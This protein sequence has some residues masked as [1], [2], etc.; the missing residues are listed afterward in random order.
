MRL[1]IA[2]HFG[3]AVAATASPHYNV[4]DRRRIE[5]VEPGVP[6][7]PI[8]HDGKALDDAAA[9]ALVALVRASAFRATAALLDRLAASLPE[10]IVTM[11]LRAWPLDFPDDIAVQRRV[12][13][14]LR[15]PRRFGMYRLVLAELANER[16]WA[17]HLYA[18][19]D[20]LG[21]AADLLK[22]RA[23]GVL[24]GPRRT[25]GPPWTK[26]HR[27]ALATAILA[28]R[29]AKLVS[30]RRRGGAGRRRRSRSR[31]RTRAGSSSA[32]A[33]VGGQGCAR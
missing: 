26:D 28:V 22:D 7:A 10:P 8:H 5:L 19:G 25:L 24:R 21:Q 14:D 29:A 4:V 33:R 30:R 23:D 18:A 12:P 6:S 17:V 3:W 2:R 13:Y 1:G 9:A 15:G 16:G 32:S 31:W 11:S 27:I 20:V